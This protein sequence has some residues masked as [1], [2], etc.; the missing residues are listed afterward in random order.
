M[1]GQID[2]SAIEQAVPALKHAQPGLKK[3]NQ[4]TSTAPTGGWVLPQVS[5]A[6][7]EM[8]EQ[9]GT[10]Q[11]SLFT[12]V[13]F[14]E[15]ACPLLGPDGERRYF[16]GRQDLEDQRR[17]GRK[18]TDLPNLKQPLASLDKEFPYRYR[19]DPRH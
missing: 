9:L 12:P 11:S 13:T 7:E 2:V 10:A 6:T 1:T 4:T 17:P 8:S 3:A 15:I 18:N 14:G 16:V 5:A 19:V